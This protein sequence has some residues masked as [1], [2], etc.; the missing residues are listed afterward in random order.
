[1]SRLV[2]LPSYVPRTRL[3]VA[4][5]TVLTRHDVPAIRLLPGVRQPVRVGEHVAN[6]LA[7]GATDRSRAGRCGAGEVAA[8]GAVA[9]SGVAELGST[10]RFRHSGAP[11]HHDRRRRPRLPAVSQCA[12]W[13]AQSLS[14]TSS[15]RRRWCTVTRI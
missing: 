12:S 15:A 10:P 7:V 6:G 3:A 8:R 11:H 2:T 1:M 4:A 9:L 5:A 13:P 14:S